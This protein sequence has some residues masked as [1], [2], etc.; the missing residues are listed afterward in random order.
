MRLAR[1]HRGPEVV[2]HV[3]VEADALAGLSRISQTRTRSVAES[4]RVPTQRI[5][6][7][8]LELGR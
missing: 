2:E 3:A 4:S 5:V 7:V 8:R 6:P 1:R